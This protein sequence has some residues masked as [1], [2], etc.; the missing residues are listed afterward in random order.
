MR[1]GNAPV[2][3]TLMHTAQLSLYHTWDLLD[4][5]GSRDP[6]SGNVRCPCLHRRPVTSTACSC[7][8]YDAPTKI[9]S[10]YFSRIFGSVVFSTWCG[11]KTLTAASHIPVSFKSIILI[12]PN[13]CREECRMN[14]FLPDVTVYTRKVAVSSWPHR[15]GVA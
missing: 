8:A 2:G 1:G 13:I 7:L 3:N 5:V 11:G 15:S 6:G 12:W 9:Y 10:I 4:D 14:L